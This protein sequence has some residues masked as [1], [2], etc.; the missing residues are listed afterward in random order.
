VMPLSLKDAREL[1]A[2]RTEL[3]GLAAY[4]AC[5]AGDVSLAPDLEV[6]NR[7]FADALNV[8][9]YTAMGASNWAFHQRILRS[10]GNAQLDRMLTDVWTAS[11]RYRLGYKLIPGRAQCTVAEHAQI[12][13]ALCSGDPERA[14]LAAR[15]HI[16]RG[17][18]ELAGIVDRTQES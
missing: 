10:A 14:R 12:I 3:E 6:I 15:N 11:W 18:A 1:F 8:T 13:E 17:G 7:R 2:V 9:D 4:S 16:Q 5:A